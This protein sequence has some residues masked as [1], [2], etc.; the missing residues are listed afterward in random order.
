MRQDAAQC[1][2]GPPRQRLPLG[3]HTGSLAA[4]LERQ[5][6]ADATVNDGLFVRRGANSNRLRVR[7]LCENW[8]CRAC[9]AGKHGFDLFLT[10]QG[11]GGC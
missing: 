4:V 7:R 10:R 2:D 1:L 6:W 3:R 5:W 8:S 9:P 11:D